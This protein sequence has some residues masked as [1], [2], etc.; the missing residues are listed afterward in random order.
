[1]AQRMSTESPRDQQA[2]IGDDLERFVRRTFAVD[3]G[4][5]NFDRSVDLFEAGYVD[6]VG[7][8]EM[9]AYIND[10]Y[11]IDV[12]D[13]HLLSEEFASIDGMAAVISRML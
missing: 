6:S 2:A 3:A 8:T 5:P 9:L 13:E 11:G 1:V 10:T 4:D 12:P 7:I